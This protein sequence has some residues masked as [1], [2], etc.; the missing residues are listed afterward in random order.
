MGINDSAEFLETRFCSHTQ[1]FGPCLN[2]SGL[3]ILH[4]RT[5][6]CSTSHWV[7]FLRVSHRVKLDWTTRS[8]TV[9]KNTSL[10]LLHMMVINLH[11][12]ITLIDMA[13]KKLSL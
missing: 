6:L 7:Q 8:V 11:K 13:L 10:R 3:N 9:R 4:W 12:Y 2:N 1:S 5:L